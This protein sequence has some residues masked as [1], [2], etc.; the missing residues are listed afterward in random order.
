MW[1][2]CQ[3]TSTNNNTNGIEINY[4][5]SLRNY[6]LLKQSN[7][8]GRGGRMKMTKIIFKTGTVLTWN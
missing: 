6:K 7:I 1:A 8:I 5:I 4:E 3:V 2:F